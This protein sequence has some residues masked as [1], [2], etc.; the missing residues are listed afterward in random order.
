MERV[1]SIVA[2]FEAVCRSP[3]G[4][5]AFKAKLNK[6]KSEYEDWHGLHLDERKF[7]IQRMEHLVRQ[8]RRL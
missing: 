3:I 5:A 6:V 4:D 7:V 8:A 2:E 1:D